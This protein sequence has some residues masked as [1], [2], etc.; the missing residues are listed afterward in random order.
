VGGATAAA[1]VLAL[2]AGFAGSIQ[3]AVMG[4][5]GERIG[6]VEAL[7]A[8]LAFS[9]VIAMTVL[10]AL[11]GG[12]GDLGAAFRSPWWYWV[13]GGGMGALVVFSITVCAP[14]IGATAT[15][16]ILIA[17]QLAMGVVIDRFGLFGVDQVA[18]T[19]SRALGVALLAVGAGLALYRG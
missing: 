10:F 5:F 14:R 4:R 11:R 8:N 19:W 16:G 6:T 1:A 7:A 3:V 13:G 12:F 18:L 17:G 2:V 9:T 15:I